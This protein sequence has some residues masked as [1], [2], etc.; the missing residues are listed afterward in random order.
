MQRDWKVDIDNLA[1][2]KYVKGQAL[3]SLVQKGLRYHHLSLTVDENG[4]QTKSLSPSMFFFGP[5]SAGKES[6]PTQKESM[7]KGSDSVRGVSPA[8]TI[9]PVPRAK[10]R[11]AAS[12]APDELMPQPAKRGR[13]PAQSLSTDPRQGVTSR[14]ISA[15]NDTEVVNGHSK[16]LTITPPIGSLTDVEIAHTTNGIH[17]D[18]MDI[19]LDAING[20]ADAVMEEV[21]EPPI[22]PL[23]PTLTTGESVAIQ[24]VPAKVA[25]L[26]P[27]S[28]VL[29]LDSPRTI[30]R[31]LWR[32]SE[33][34]ALIAQGESFCGVWNLSGHDL[35]PH[36][37]KPPLT[38]FFDAGEPGWVTACTWDTYGSFLALATYSEQGQI[39][40]FEG[41]D[42]VLF[43]SLPASRRAIT[44][45]KWHPDNAQLIGLSPNHEGLEQSNGTIGSTLLSWNVGSGSGGSSPSTLTLPSTVYDID[46][47]AGSETHD[48]LVAC[49]GAV[50]RCSTAGGLKIVNQWTTG[51]NLMGREVWTFIRATNS[52]THGRTVIAAATE[53]SSIW[54]P[55]RGVFKANAHMGPITGLE[56]RPRRHSANGE[57]EDL[58]IATSDLE[59]F[60][61]TWRLNE[62]NSELTCV[63]QLRFEPRAPLMCLSYSPDGFCLAATSYT[64][65][66]IWNAQHNYNL[67]ASWEGKEPEWKGSSIK[68]DELASG[69]GRSSADADSDG[70]SS[71]ADHTLSWHMDSKRLAF[72]FGSQVAVIDFQR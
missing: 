34:T 29:A 30:K 54:L 7:L 28:A 67:M 39:H 37:V 70:A 8:S 10:P 45:L 1:F 68:D 21:V 66:C 57:Y 36:S 38:S 26:A 69:G 72:G 52:S 44:M 9:A 71:S 22:P 59:G 47:V 11:D 16:Q 23:I 2:A 18:K 56:V 51:S 27:T 40:L 41:Q 4:Q 42:L 49:D 43:E 55:D 19:D 50:Y 48:I 24:V 65:A 32:P 63:H 33:S 17:E 31:A 15:S 58:E 60:V 12:V 62:G 64:T 53:S 13:K 14:K 46:C 3:I 61:K 35:H 20:P 25:N 6:V 5:E